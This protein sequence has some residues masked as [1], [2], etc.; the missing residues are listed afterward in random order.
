KR[1][2]E[3]P[4][5]DPFRPSAIFERLLGLDPRIVFTTNYDKLFETASQGGYATHRFDSTT[6]GADL[7]RGD[8]V[9][10]KLHG[11]TDSITE[12]VLTR[13]DY[14]RLMRT[15]SAVLAA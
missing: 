11:S 15:G 5:A 2:V 10:I 4:P 3:G 12:V 8:A 6:L 7:R 13:T 9:L 14:A 1:S